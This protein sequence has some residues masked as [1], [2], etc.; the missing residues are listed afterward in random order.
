ME[1]EHHLKG[2]RHYQ[3]NI[4]SQ[5]RVI[6][7]NSTCFSINKEIIENISGCVKFARKSTHQQR[8]KS[9]SQQVYKSKI[10]SFIKSNH[11]RLESITNNEGKITYPNCK[12]DL[13]LK[14]P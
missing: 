13:K 8:L 7:H 11:M 3:I 14:C 2:V 6:F 12:K 1:N 10:M 5:F 4:L 9:I